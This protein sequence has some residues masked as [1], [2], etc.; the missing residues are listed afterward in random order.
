MNNT[1]ILPKQSSTYDPLNLLQIGDPRKN[2]NIPLI[3]PISMPLMMP[4]IMQRTAIFTPTGPNPIEFK[5]LPQQEMGQG[6]FTPTLPKGQFIPQLIGGDHKHNM[7]TFGGNGSEDLDTLSYMYMVNPEAFIKTMQPAGILSTF[8]Q[9][10]PYYKFATNFR[11]KDEADL[12]I[13]QDSQRPGQALH[14]NAPGN[15]DA[16]PN[17]L[18]VASKVDL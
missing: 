3:N 9:E 6:L 14:V 1:M 7:N 18:A 10:N 5:G 16:I 4:G 13:N 12:V 2:M 8:L 11:H 15:N 17:R